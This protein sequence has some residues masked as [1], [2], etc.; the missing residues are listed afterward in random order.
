[1]IQI[2][3]RDCNGKR[4]IWEFD[5][6]DEFSDFYNKNNEHVDDD[7]YEVQMVIYD[8]YCVYSALQGCYY[9]NGGITFEELV[10]FL[11]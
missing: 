7:M 3:V 11:A 8:G 5:T 6:T 4:E 1:M 10:G 9:G 2:Y